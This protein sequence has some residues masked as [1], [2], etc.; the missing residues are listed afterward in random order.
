MA[1][2]LVVAWLCNRI[3]PAPKRDE[4]VLGGSPIS[5]TP[6]LSVVSDLFGKGV[7]SNKGLRLPVVRLL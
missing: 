3:H 5:R 6:C 1:L 2:S 4:I 7:D